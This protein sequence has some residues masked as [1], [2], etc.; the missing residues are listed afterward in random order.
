MCPS[1]AKGY[2]GQQLEVLDHSVNKF[3]ELTKNSGRFR[4]AEGSCSGIIRSEDLVDALDIATL[5]KVVEWACKAL[6]A[7]RVEDG[8]FLGM[9]SAG[10][11]VFL[12]PNAVMCKRCFL[13]PIEPAGCEDM[14]THQG[15]V[16]PG[17]TAPVNNSC[18][19][20]G[21]FGADRGQWLPWDGIL[22]TRKT[23]EQVSNNG[24]E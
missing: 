21:W 4:C 10:S 7:K 16:M 5:S 12:F 24:T 11:T 23:P 6:N 19:E 13:G 22:R 2:I 20:C 14:N 17:S 8:D 3:R 15:V 18:P 1:C 9:D